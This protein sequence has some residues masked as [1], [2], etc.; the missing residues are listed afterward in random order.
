MRFNARQTLSVMESMRRPNGTFW[1]SVSPNY[2]AMWLRDTL[3]CVFAY[4][5][6]GDYE[7]LK[8][9]IRVIFDLFKKYRPKIKTRIASPK[10]IA[11]GVL[12]AKYDA[13]TLSEIA[14]DDNWAHNQLD[15][16]GLFLHVVA[17]LDFKNVRVIRDEED[18]RTLELL[19]AYLRSVEYWQ[20]PDFGMWEEC[21]IHHSSS[22][23][24]VVG[25]LTRIRN[26]RIVDVPDTLIRAGEQALREILPHESRDACRIQHHKH[27][28]DSAQLSLFWPYNVVPN[29]A[30]ADELLSRIIAGHI[31]GERHNLVQRHG[32]N[33]YWGDDYYR[34]TLEHYR[35]VSAEWP[36]FLFWISIIYSQRHEYDKAAAWFRKGAEEVVDDKI[37]EAYQNGRP[38]DQTPLAWAHAIAL[39]AWSKLPEETQ[40]KVNTN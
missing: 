22:I 5:Y 19:V 18:V 7:K 40:R 32:L 27:D 23:G 29:P 11:G 8:K 36:M 26:R 16:I 24:A 12:H 9:G 3:Y 39:V 37:P 4:W 21:K 6:L 17:D 13:D 14:T 15:V 20:E 30:K 33:R 31:N 34:S 2:R 1:A 28:C 38:N 35:G 25:G 10:D